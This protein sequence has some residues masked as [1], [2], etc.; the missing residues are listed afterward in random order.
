MLGQGSYGRAYLVKD[1][2][3]A[4]KVIK[5]SAPLNAE[6]ARKEAKFLVELRHPH[7]A[8]FYQAAAFLNKNSKKQNTLIFLIQKWG[9][10]L[11]A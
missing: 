11:A 9:Q 5:V 2:T 7:I 10:K 4:D 8:S 3:G 1:R 6:E